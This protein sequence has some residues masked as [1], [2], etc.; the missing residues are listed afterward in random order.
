V[1]LPRLL[2]PRPVPARFFCRDTY[3]SAVIRR[4]Y[5]NVWDFAIDVM[6]KEPS[7]LHSLRTYNAVADILHL[8]QAKA[9]LVLANSFD[10]PVKAS[11]MTGPPGPHV[12]TQVVILIHVNLAWFI[13]AFFALSAAAH[14]TVAGPAWSSYQREL[15]SE[16]NPYRWIEYSLSASIM[17]MLIGMLTGITDVSALIALV[18][19]N[20]SMIGFGWMQERYEHPGGSLGPFWIGCL[21]GDDAVARHWP[22]PDWFGCLAACSR[23]RLRDL[24]LA[25]RIL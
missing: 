16:R 7:T 5:D 6:N 20:A 22:L 24:L 2:T 10:L 11:Y 8:L 13:F 25:F 3:L 19:V 23:I 12:G 18:G 15:V 9:I 4:T 14:F 21:A 17:I 1:E